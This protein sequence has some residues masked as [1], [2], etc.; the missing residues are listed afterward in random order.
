MNYITGALLGMAGYSVTTLLVKLATRGGQL[1]SFVVLAIATCIVFVSVLAIC[2][3]RG[4][5][6]TLQARDLR[7]PSAGLAGAAGI[8]LTIAV[9]SLFRVLSLGPASRSCRSPACSSSSARFLERF[10]CANR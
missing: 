8:A 7:G 2:L 1:S 4:E 3:A 9:A 10:S 5:M 6:A